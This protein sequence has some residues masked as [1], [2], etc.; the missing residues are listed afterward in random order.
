MLSNGGIFNPVIGVEP[1]GARSRAAFFDH[2]GPTSYATGGEPLTPSSSLGGANQLGLASFSFLDPPL[3]TNSG[4]YTLQVV[5]GGTGNRQKVNV[6]WRPANLTPPGALL[7]LGTLSS[8]AT[9]STYTAAGL[10]T[11]VGANTLKAGQFISLSNGASAAGIFLNGVI[12]QVVSATTT[13]YTFNFGQ[14]VALAYTIATDTL[15]YQLVQVNSSNLLQAYTLPSPI[16]GVLAT[17]NLLTITQANTLSPGQ[18]VYLNGP[19]KAASV[20]ALGALVQVQTA[21]AT[22]WTANWQGTIIAQ[23]SAEVAVASLV[24]TNGQVPIVS[25]PYVDLPTALLSNVLTVASGAS[26][27]GLFTLTALQAYQAGMIIVVQAVG[28]STELNGSIGTVI[29][30]GLT[31]AIIKANGWTVL[32]NTQA[33]TLGYASLLGTGLP[34]GNGEVLPG[35]NLSAEFA[36]MIAI[37][38]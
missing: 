2:Y 12:V 11:V 4:N 10:V 8:A 20:Y 27:A 17:A 31:Q 21:T 5:Y 16:T 14:G 35:T 9:Q 32:Q 28:T 33:E 26:A 29:A 22:G 3:T 1:W 34:T 6:I 23:T 30:S 15:K 25:Y 37:G 24:V 13:G 18:F 36:R 38:T 19:F 7:S